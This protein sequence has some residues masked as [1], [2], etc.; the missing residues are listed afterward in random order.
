MS[1][2]HIRILNF[3]D[4]V[5]KQKNLLSQY[6]AEII[7]LRDIGPNVRFWLNDKDRREIIK[8]IRGSRADAVTFLGS[9]DF[10]HITDMLIRE[11]SEPVS[12]I[13]FDLHPDW[14][15][16]PPWL[17]CGSWVRHTVKDRNVLKCILIGTGC[18]A[19]SFSIQGGDFKSLRDNRVEIYPY[20]HEQSAVFFRNIPPNISMET[21]RYP[22]FTKI[23]WDELKNKN[24][25]EFFLHIL[26]HLPAKKVYVTIDK[27]C[28]TAA[29]ALTN[30]EEGK[31]PLDDLLLMLR[32][33][34]ENLDVVG[35]DIV[36]EYSP[37]HVNGALKKI[38]SYLNH[39]AKTPA[40]D[41][42][43]S[44][45]TAVNEKTNLKILEII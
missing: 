13:A 36:G 12:V 43:E 23:H 25:T 19:L 11:F 2:K 32:I 42:S 31:L 21:E 27:D 9:G 6:S 22:F 33:I 18:N 40:K 29:D 34:K 45:I 8:R 39:P 7:D 35:M 30:W 28:L 37:I 15:I 24:L 1:D 14:S 16:L 26:G 3:D 44:P 5:I 20:S 38:A 4:S 17:S 10:H 41:L